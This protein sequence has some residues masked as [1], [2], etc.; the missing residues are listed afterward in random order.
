M[1]LVKELQLRKRNDTS[2]LQISSAETVTVVSL[3]D[4][5]IFHFY[6]GKHR[7]PLISIHMGI[8]VNFR[9]KITNRFIY[10]YLKYEVIQIFRL[11][12]VRRPSTD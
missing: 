4:H 6:F 9:R 11:S 2:H 7:F 8:S 5:L 12:F 3:L 1:S 10:I